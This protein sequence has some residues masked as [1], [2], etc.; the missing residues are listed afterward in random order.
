MGQSDRIRYLLNRY[1]DNSCT[2]QEMDELLNYVQK[3]PEDE[4]LRAALQQAW[5][6]EKSLVDSG[7]PDWIEMQ[8]SLR[9]LSA[10]E[11][12]RYRERFSWKAAACVLVL[13]ACCA[14]FFFWHENKNASLAENQPSLKNAVK[15]AKDE[16]RLIVLLDGS[17]VWING[18]SKLACAPAFNNQTREVTLHGE[19][20]FDI[21][22]DPHRPFIINTGNVK[23]TVLGTA[24]NIRAFPGENAVTVTVTRGKVRVEAEN[25]KG[26]TITAN[27]QLTLNLTSEQLEE[28][29]VNA[30]AVSEWI[31]DDLILYNVTFHEVEE[32]LEDR[33]SVDIRFDNALLKECRFTSTFFQNASLDEVLTTICLVNGASYKINDKVITIYGNGCHEKSSNQ[34]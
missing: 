5:D 27:Q 19:A 22:H 12:V 9:D 34:Y 31:K 32:I 17:K 24:F 10:S 11:N 1:L 7:E 23:T 13:A 4:H 25:K 16:H 20:F 33:Y 15:T 26:G 8:E 6:A 2:R 29:A 3:N 14:A 30:E 21:R 18:N 28:H